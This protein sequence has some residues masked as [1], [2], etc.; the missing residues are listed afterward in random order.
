MM[1]MIIMI[2]IKIIIIITKIIRLMTIIVLKTIMIIIIQKMR[3]SPPPP[4]LGLMYTNLSK[5][6]REEPF[7]WL[8]GTIPATSSTVGKI[9]R[10]SATRSDVLLRATVTLGKFTGQDTIIGTCDDPRNEQFDDKYYKKIC[11]QNIK[12][13]IRESKMERAPF[14]NSTTMSKVLLA[15]LMLVKLNGRETSIGT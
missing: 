8:C 12:V 9:S 10:N 7:N 2:R 11:A 14:L 13:C 4:H 5:H 1:I 6:A 3:I 15:S